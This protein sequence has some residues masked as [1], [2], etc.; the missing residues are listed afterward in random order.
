MHIPLVEGRDFNELDDRQAESVMIVNQKFVRRFFGARDPIGRKVHGWGRWFTIVGVVRDSK[1]HMPNEDQRAL[2]YVPFRQVY[3][4]D[5][6]IAIYAR[7]E[8]DP[9]LAAAAL[10]RAVRRMDP[11]VGVFMLSPLSEYITASLFAQK[12][13]ASL[14]AVLSAIAMVLAAVGLYSVMAYSITQRIQEIGIRVALGAGFWNV[15]ALV[16]RQAA[17]IVVL[18]MAIGAG[19]AAALTRVASNLLVKV[20][21]TDPMVFGGAVVFLAVVGIIAVSVPATQAT[22]IDPNVALRAE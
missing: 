5:L 3:R 6:G 17:G 4:E 15:L 22:R 13:A 11:N 12:V 10:R 20:S 2:F 16:G 8:G 1:F 18:G 19:I 7:T 9:K 14:M 21:P